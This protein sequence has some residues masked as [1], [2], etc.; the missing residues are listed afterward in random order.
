[1]ESIIGGN[2]GK[3]W[4]SLK[5]KGAQ[6]ASA[7]GRA[8]GLKASELDR[9]IGWLAREGKLTFTTDEKGTIKIGLKS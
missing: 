5:D 6:S 4:Q 2:A 1:M 3:I 9:G 8:T 7:L